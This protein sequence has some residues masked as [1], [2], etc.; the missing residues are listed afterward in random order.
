[1]RVDLSDVL[2]GIRVGSMA[3][4]RSVAAAVQNFLARQ[5]Y[6]AELHSYNNRVLT[7]AAPP[8]ER[9][10]LQYDLAALRTH[11]DSSGQGHLVDRVQVRTVVYA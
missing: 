2:S 9:A 3:E 4:R 10:L 6:T 8:A 1:M 7:L 11:L 5:G